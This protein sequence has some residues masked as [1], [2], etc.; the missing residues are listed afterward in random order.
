[1]PTDRTGISEIELVSSMRQGD[2]ASAAL[3]PPPTGLAR[4]DWKS[5]GIL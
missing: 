1:V 2:D 4:A 3:C 5:V